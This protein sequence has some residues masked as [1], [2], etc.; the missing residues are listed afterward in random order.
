MFMAVLFALGGVAIGIYAFASRGG[1]VN[2]SARTAVTVVGIVLPLVFFAG[3]YAL[4]RVVVPPKARGVTVTVPVTEV[5]RGAAV[6][7]RLELSTDK[8]GLELGLVCMEYYDI[9]T[10]DGR[11]NRSRN[12]SQAV[13]Y[14]DWRP[15]SGGATQSVRFDVPVNAPY[16]YRGDCLSYVWRVSARQPKRMRFDRA[17]NVP[18]VVRP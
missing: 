4:L 14:E 15:Q 3:A 13:A 8:P 18:I 7:A 1:A 10:T 16:S 9:E 11:G 2:D 5:R 6:D 12:T 17:V